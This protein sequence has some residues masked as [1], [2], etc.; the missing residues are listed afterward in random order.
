[1][2]E[3][4]NTQNVQE[5]IILFYYNEGKRLPEDLKYAFISLRNVCSSA[6]LPPVFTLRVHSSSLC[7]SDRQNI[8]EHC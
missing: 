3:T 6:L 2:Y 5:Y 7:G 4:R 1:M 8:S